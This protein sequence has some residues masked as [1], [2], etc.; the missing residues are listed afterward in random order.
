MLIDDDLEPKNRPKKPKPLDTMSVEELGT[1]VDELKA[2]IV[3][4]EA[5][6]AAKT[7]HLAAAESLFKKPG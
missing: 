2:E 5:A 7:S 1:Y 3:R 4:A 6:I